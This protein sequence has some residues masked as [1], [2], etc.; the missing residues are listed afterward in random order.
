MNQEPA[1]PLFG[2]TQV[3]MS[4]AI[5]L[6]AV[7]I[8]LAALLAGFLLSEVRQGPEGEGGA[9]LGLGPIGSFDNP[10][11]IGND[12]TFPG[13]GTLRVV[14]SSWRS[15]Q[16][17]FAIVN[18]EFRCERPSGQ[19]CDTGDLMFAVVGG[20]GNGYEQ[21]FDSAIPEPTFGSFANP[22]VYGGGR[23]RG[24]AGFLI[25]GSESSLKMRV[26]LFLEDTD[27]FFNI[28]Y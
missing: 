18:L 11:P 27:Y 28:S 1:R 22:P 5:G 13:L 10:V 7:L 14:S 21:K 19:E 20:S 26:G 16:T 24:N 6:G 12:F 23:E 9:E 15:G 25:T 8:C 4:I 2:L 3:E 17:G